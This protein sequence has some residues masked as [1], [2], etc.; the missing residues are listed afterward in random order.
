MVLV[1]VPLAK[2]LVGLATTVEVAGETAPVAKVSVADR[3][4]TMLSV[5]S[6][7]ERV[8]LPEVPETIWKVAI[9]LALLVT[10]A[11]GVM[12][13]LGP[14]MLAAVAAIDTLTPG[15]GLE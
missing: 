2:T 15:T 10:G 3:A 14:G 6:V 13:T 8:A 5:V 9:P 1:A 12:V 11:D 7:A 4:R